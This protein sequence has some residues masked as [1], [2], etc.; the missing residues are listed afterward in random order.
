MN[1]DDLKEGS[2]SSE[3]REFLSMVE[4][5]SAQSCLHT[6][7]I[8]RGWSHGSPG[9]SAALIKMFTSQFTVMQ[10]PQCC[11]GPRRSAGATRH[12]W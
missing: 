12:H 11:L 8:F 1:S 5:S 6:D 3:S 4:G 10:L 7:D 9:T 2:G